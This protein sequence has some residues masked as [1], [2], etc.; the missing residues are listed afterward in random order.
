MDAHL[1]LISSREKLRTSVLT[2]SSQRAG[3]VPPGHGIC[4]P[5][6]R[7]RNRCKHI[8][9]RLTGPGGLISRGALFLRPALGALCLLLFMTAAPAQDLD[10]RA[11]A[12][13]P[14]DM[15]FTVAGFSY[16][17]G[18]VLT[19]ES[20]PIQDLRAAVETPSLS[21][22]RTFSLFG[23]TAQAFAALPYS[24]AQVSGLVLGEGRSITRSGF[25]DIR[26]RLS[27]LVYG[28]PA[29]TADKFANVSHQ[30]IVGASLSVVAPTG[31]FFSEKLINLGA[32][33]W[34]FKPEIALSH[35]VGERWLIDLYA[36]VWLFTTNDSFYPGTSV[37]TQD[38]LAAFQAHLSYNLQPRM[39]VAFDATYYAGGLS[40]V[41]GVNMDDRQNNMRIGGTVVV[42][43]GDRHSV[44]FACS[45]GAIVRIGANFTTFAF[46]W[47]TSFF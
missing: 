15:T 30:T 39:W 10:P 5:D 25:S 42:P 45:T 26:L 2:G 18:G 31:Q 4:D 27:L 12:R 32:N 19:D 20:S 11:Y 22:G 21:I 9:R 36:G 29:T 24:W 46:G 7:E 38:P 3:H 43:V 17:H 28:A 13:V 44:K 37:R 35:P 47:Q 33:R 16:S 6:L 23:Q 34:A 1:F 14:V 8:T 40:S 41:N